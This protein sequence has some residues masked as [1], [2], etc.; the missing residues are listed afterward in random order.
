VIGVIGV[1]FIAVRRPAP[2]AMILHHEIDKQPAGA[3][4]TWMII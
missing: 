1:C 4:K 2:K 3:L